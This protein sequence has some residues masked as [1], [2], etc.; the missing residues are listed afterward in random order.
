MKLY[1][2]RH[3]EAK[4]DAEDPARPLSTRGRAETERVAVFLKNTDSVRVSHMPHSGKTRSA[5][6]AAILA[7]CLG[8]PDAVLERDGMKP[9]D[10]PIIWAD[11]LAEMHNDVMLVGH[12]PHIGKLAG[13][14]LCDDADV[15]PITFGA[16]CVACLERDE[17]DCWT[18][19][20]L[21]GPELLPCSL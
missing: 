15:R 8:C 11:R 13:L 5:E 9:N 4:P 10:D 6:T 21:V 2:A 12:L 1:L 19:A 14:L 18:V 17:G 20:W 3:G 16:S 7:G